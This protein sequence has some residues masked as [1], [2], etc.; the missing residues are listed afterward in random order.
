MTPGTLLNRWLTGHVVLGAL[1][2]VVVLHHATSVVYWW[3]EARGAV[4]VNSLPNGCLEHL[5]PQC[6]R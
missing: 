3:F 6:F 1:L 4:S 5:L 2:G